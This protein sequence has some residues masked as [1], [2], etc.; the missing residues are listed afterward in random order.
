M[1]TTEKIYSIFISKETLDNRSMSVFKTWLYKDTYKKY[2]KIHNL[3]EEK[4]EEFMTTNELI[5][6]EIINIIPIEQNSI[7]LNTIGVILTL[8]IYYSINPAELILTNILNKDNS[9][10]KDATV[11]RILSF[12]EK[13]LGYSYISYSISRNIICLYDLFFNKKILKEPLPTNTAIQTSVKSNV[14]SGG[15]QPVKSGE[16]EKSFPSEFLSEYNLVD[17]EKYNIYKLCKIIMESIINTLAIFPYGATI[18]TQIDIN[19]DWFDIMLNILLEAG[20]DN[21]YLSTKD[22]LNNNYNYKFVGLTKKNYF[23]SVTEK[24]ILDGYNKIL[25]L[26]DQN[27]INCTPV[28]DDT[29]VQ[30]CICNM[31][32]FFNEDLTKWLS[33]L[34][35]N[36]QTINIKTNGIQDITQKEFSGAF[37]IKNINEVNNESL[38]EGV[39]ESK[40]GEYNK[41][42]ICELELDERSVTCSG[43][44][45][46]TIDNTLNYIKT[47]I[48]D[49]TSISNKLNDIESNAN[50]IINNSGNITFG[51]DLF[52]N[53]KNSSTPKEFQESKAG[54]ITPI[55]EAFKDIMEKTQNMKNQI[56]AIINEERNKNIEIIKYLEKNKLSQLTY[57]LSGKEN[58]V[59]ATEGL[60]QFHTHPYQEYIKYNW[61]NCFPSGPDFSSFL[62][63]LSN[64][65]IASIVIAVEGLYTIS[66]NKKMCEVN[67]FNRLINAIK[68]TNLLGRINYCFDFDKNGTPEEFCDIINTLKYNDKICCDKINSKLTEI[69]SF[70]VGEKVTLQN[71]PGEMLI[72]EIKSEGGKSYRLRNTKTTEESKDMIPEQY[73]SK[74]NNEM[75]QPFIKINLGSRQEYSDL[76]KF[77]YE[78]ENSHPLFK[79]EFKTWAELSNIRT[80]KFDITYPQ[81]FN[82]CI[83]DHETFNIIKELYTPTELIYNS[84]IANP[85]ELPKVRP[86]LT[87]STPSSPLSNTSTSPTSLPISL[88]TSPLKI[89]LPRERSLTEYEFSPDT[90]VSR[91]R[92]SSTSGFSSKEGRT[93]VPSPDFN[94][95]LKDYMSMPDPPEVGEQFPN[96]SKGFE[97]FNFGYRSPSP[98]LP[99]FSQRPPTPD[100][101]L[102]SNSSPGLTPDYRLHSKSSPGFEDFLPPPSLQRQSSINKSPPSSPSSMISRGRSN[103]KMT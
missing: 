47:Y 79:C 12:S 62:S 93:Q 29:V 72:I 98:T 69:N 49:S 101:R 19:N 39:E 76:L 42:F 8:P 26:F 9:V 33:R 36:T 7:P 14:Y 54:I 35:Y 45:I 73:I 43:E 99:G 16:S 60:I 30:T 10:D 59:T 67:N 44:R 83:N 78:G 28:I 64:G 18:W 37:K 95:I 51:D 90:S 92:F 91:R 56:Q 4:E 82:Q 57:I 71:N 31:K 75:L 15:L 103:T 17:Y 68:N 81:L 1:D 46:K 48:N 13:I 66:I 96:L 23:K 55:T 2:I 38:G 85:L 86:I 61:K 63:S 24:N 40:N 80:N 3:K 22:P 27:I 84:N 102:H 25:Y 100:Y 97:Q 32:L 74:L 50:Y 6:P 70:K 58:T 21:P 89:V 5:K 87:V 11:S 65:T 20:F 52:N 77:L 94:K 34:P 41:K 88:E 53:I